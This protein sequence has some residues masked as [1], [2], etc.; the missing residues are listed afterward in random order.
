MRYSASGTN[1]LM[2]WQKAAKIGGSI[3]EN[4]EPGTPRKYG[5]DAWVEVVGTEPI[6]VSGTW[7]SELPEVARRTY[8]K[9]LGL[10]IKKGLVYRNN[11]GDMVPVSDVKIVD[12]YEGW[13]TLMVRLADGTSPKMNIHQMHFAEM[14]TGAADKS[15]QEND[16]QKQRPG[17]KRPQKS[18]G[19]VEGMPLDFIVFDIEA[20]GINCQSDEICEIAALKVRDGDVVDTFEQFV[21]IDGDMPRAAKA[22]NHISKEML[23]DAPHMT[24]ALSAFLGFIGT[25]AIL[26]GHNINAYD[27]PFIERVSGLCGLEFTYSRA[28]DILPLARRAW[29]N[30]GT[31]SMDSLRTTLELDADGAHRALKDCQD[32]LDV[33]MAIRGDVAAGKAS[34]A[35]KK[36]ASAGSHA[37]FSSKWQRRKAKEFTTDITEFDHGHPIFGK[38]VVISGNITGHSY[39]DCM[40]RVKDLGGEP[41][42]NVTRKTNYLV[43]GEDHGNGK[44]AKAEEYMAAGQDIRIIGGDEF[45]GLVGWEI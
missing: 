10:P 38:F 31:Y 26:V 16:E 3:P 19:K 34:I 9:E 20:T 18:G 35:E 36:R 27:L 21:Y 43:V 11:G 1:D 2:P 4:P 25:D 30:R 29:P 42:D 15:L 13:C 28:V 8:L 14:N 45:L 33:Y 5:V 22:V 40:Q 24:A 32:E 39:D 23:E 37:A 7:L 6:R 41:Q 17:Q 44:L 12:V